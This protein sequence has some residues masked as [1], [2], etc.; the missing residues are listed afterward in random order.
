MRFLIS[1]TFCSAFCFVFCAA[2][3][4]SP[5]IAQ[6][7]FN[8]NTLADEWEK[9]WN[10]NNLFPSTFDAQADPDADGWKN[11]IE[12]LAGTN[13]FDSR[14]PTG[15]IVPT[16]SVIPATYQPVPPAPEPL[17][18]PSPS[19]DPSAPATTTTLSPP[20][21]TPA[22]ILL[23]PALI[24]LTWPTIPGK[25]YRAHVSPDLLTWASA[26]ETFLGDGEAMTYQTAPINTDGSVP[27]K[28]FWRIETGDT[29]SDLD[30][31]TDYEE[32]RRTLN[33]FPPS[34]SPAAPPIAAL[35]TA[36]ANPLAS[37][38]KIH[39]PEKASPLFPS[40]RLVSSSSRLAKTPA[41]AVKTPSR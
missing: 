11:I 26:S 1:S 32:I 29:D 6:V 31:L 23:D 34:P 21:A 35:S 9:A 2:F 7:D 13:P 12:S 10:N 30:T 33:P 24:T 39:L 15:I 19:E 28:L 27:G 14:P 4:I 17:I 16:I 18:L 37:S 25:T 38:A 20:P 5:A 8:A 40:T 41:C 3:L 22:P 36:S